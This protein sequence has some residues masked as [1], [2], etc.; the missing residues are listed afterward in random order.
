MVLIVAGFSKMRCY[1][2][3][4]GVLNTTLS[5]V[6]DTT[7]TEN[8]RKWVDLGLS[9]V[10]PATNVSQSRKWTTVSIRSCRIP[11]VRLD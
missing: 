4:Y 11:L 7:Y 9:I 3:G 5:S 1:K 10:Y 8:G 2:T 6:I